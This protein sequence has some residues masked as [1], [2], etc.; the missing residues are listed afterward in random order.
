VVE[1]GTANLEE[2]ISEEHRRLAPFFEGV[3]EALGTGDAVAMRPA[4]DQLHDEL[5]RHLAQEDR[6]YYPTLSTLRP[7]HRETLHHFVTDHGSFRADL[8]VIGDRLEAGEIAEARTRFD[9]LVRSFA[10]HEVQEEDF[11]RRIDATL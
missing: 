5:E 10:A 6:L 1:E 8:E 2:Q 7:E 4:F 11:L 3:R 9:A